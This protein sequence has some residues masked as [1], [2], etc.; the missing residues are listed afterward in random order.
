MS[1]SYFGGT[2]KVVQRDGQINIKIKDRQDANGKITSTDE[3][4]Q[5]IYANVVFP[6]DK[7]YNTEFDQTS[8][9]ISFYSRS[10]LEF[11]W[12]KDEYRVKLTNGKQSSM[13]KDNR[14]AERVFDL[15]T[16]TYNQTAIGKGEWW[17][18]EFEGGYHKITK[19]TVLNRKQDPHMLS[20]TI[21]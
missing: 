14:G 16:E 17:S 2:A 8:N 3:E 9:S 1:G 19:I 5:I 10:K 11:K 21:I 12:T 4:K 13:T 18:C 15:T 6:D 7:A 20:D